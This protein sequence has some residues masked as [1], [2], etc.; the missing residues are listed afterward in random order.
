MYRVPYDRL[1]RSDKWAT[2]V[3]DCVL[4]RRDA[5]VFHCDRGEVTRIH[6]SSSRRGPSLPCRSWRRLWDAMRCIGQLQMSTISFSRFAADVMI[7]SILKESK[8]A[9]LSVT[10]V[11]REQT[12]RSCMRAR[13]FMKTVGHTSLCNVPSYID[14]V[15]RYVVT[16]IAIRKSRSSAH[17]HGSNNNAVFL[18]SMRIASIYHVMLSDE[19]SGG[20]SIWRFDW[21]VIEIGCWNW[22]PNCRLVV[23]IEHVTV[24]I[25]TCENVNP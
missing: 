7:S 2:N 24:L 14:P 19:Q 18:P 10:I 16:V 12:I 25:K 20:R 6:T 8:L 11:S 15:V 9:L 3:K 1:H 4:W 17:L 13:P 5:R 22:R 21:R 23:L